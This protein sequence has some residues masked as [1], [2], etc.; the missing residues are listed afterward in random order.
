MRQFIVEPGGWILTAD[1]KN[2]HPWILAFISGD[3]QLKVDVEA[4]IYERVEK[5]FNV[6]RGAAKKL[7]V[8]WINGQG[9]AGADLLLNGNAVDT[10]KVFSSWWPQAARYIEDKERAARLLGAPKPWAAAGAELV[11]IEGEALG[12]VIESLEGFF[13]GEKTIETLLPLHDGVVFRVLSLSGVSRS[14]ETIVQA[15]GS[16]WS[17]A[18]GS[19]NNR[20][21][22]EIKMGSSWGSAQV[23]EK[24]EEGAL[25][26]KAGPAFPPRDALS[27]VYTTAIVSLGTG[28]DRKKVVSST[29]M[30]RIYALFS[31][32]NRGRGRP[33]VMFR[34]GEVFGSATS[35]ATGLR[36]WVVNARK[37]STMASGQN[38]RNSEGN[39]N[40][41]E[42]GPEIA[43]FDASWADVS[44]S[45]CVIDGGLRRMEAGLWKSGT[46]KGLEAIIGERVLRIARSVGGNVSA[47]RVKSV[48]ALIINRFR[49]EDELRRIGKSTERRETELR[50]VFADGWVLDRGGTARRV[51]FDDYVLEEEALSVPYEADVNVDEDDRKLLSWFREVW[52]VLKQR[53]ANVDY[54]AEQVCSA[55][56]GVA[57]R[58]PR[59]SLLVGEGA[60]GKSTLLD[61]VS[62]VFHSKVVSHLAPQEV[63]G[64]RKA[65][66]I[67]SRVNIAADISADDVHTH[68]ALKSLV[69]GSPVSTDVKYGEETKF[70][71]KA[72]WFFS[73]NKVPAFRDASMGMARRLFV[74]NFPETFYGREDL[75]IKTWFS[76]P[77]G[78]AALVRW[79]R[80]AESRVLNWSWKLTAPFESA[81]IVDRVMLE[82]DPVRSFVMDCT[83]QGSGRRITTRELYD[84]YLGWSKSTGHKAPM[85]YRRWLRELEAVARSKIRKMSFVLD[86]DS[87]GK[88]WTSLLY[89]DPT[90][91]YWVNRPQEVS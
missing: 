6:D 5:E 16:A 72:A 79:A 70:V 84:Q 3:A 60:D 65:S 25:L 27:D 86:V 59:I 13:G 37:Q 80:T 54:L 4:G 57:D 61:A 15:F 62:G 53:E 32:L 30:E 2:S 42:S 14:I 1:V 39:E 64:F 91:E 41:N 76:S 77:A 48:V 26:A 9:K 44:D 36:V 82:A 17:F 85:G 19:E 67:G 66:L 7:V 78:R 81:D 88:T 38:I 28:K 68:V 8:G 50:L 55:L 35:L 23:I 10:R 74:V 24:Y 47:A 34:E 90:T 31:A 33:S 83:R 40:N 12:K 89:V 52:P 51:S 11:K 56:W 43:L 63:A 69:D 46:G 45:F 21:K 22:V 87:Y 75:D 29:R 71:A 58:R 18:A 49:S 20:P 73:M